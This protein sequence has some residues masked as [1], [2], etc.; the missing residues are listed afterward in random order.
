MKL[1]KSFMI[2]LTII[3]AFSM[4]LAACGQN[5]AGK[6]DNKSGNTDSKDGDKKAAEPK[7][8]GTLVAG[9]QSDSGFEGLLERGFYSG[10]PDD[11]IL[12]FMMD[13]LFKYDDEL[14]VQPHIAEWDTKD[15]QTYTFK[16]KEGVKWHNGEELTVEDWKYALEVIAH[17]DYEGPRYTNVE[18]IKGAEEYKKGKAK[19]ISGI[20]VINDYEIEITFIE[21]RVNH[22][23][24]IWSYPMPRKH[25]EGIAV[26][27][28]SKSPKVRKEPIGLGPF[29]VKKVQGNEY[30]EMER[31]DDYWQGKPKLDKLI[32]K[33][34]D[35]SLVAGALK[36]GEIDYMDVAPFQLEELSKLDNIEVHDVPDVSY[37][38]VGFKFG[39]WDKKEGKAVMDNKKFQNKDLRK[40]MLY[41]ID[42]EALI[43]AYLFDK[44]KVLNTVIPSNHWIAA[45]PSELEDYK[46]DPEK[47]KELL[48]KAGYKDVNG[49]GFVED[50]DGK[51]FK[52]SFSA[53]AKDSTYEGRAQQLLQNWKDVGLNV[54]L[55]S[56]KLLDFDLMGEMKDKD[57]PSIELYLAG[58]QT[59][60]DPD[61]TGLWA[62][63]AFWN[64]PRWVNE[65]SD[66]LLKEALG[67]KAME[68][69]NYRKDTYV[70]WQKLMNEELPVLPLWEPVDLL[71]M[72]KRVHGPHIGLGTDTKLHE[73][74]VSE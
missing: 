14:K 12:N 24:N 63:N 44:A 55:N 37:W 50:P 17:K 46:Y 9:L 11:Y 29:K 67:K 66:T 34:V 25:Y 43:K 59:G 16:F 30:V 64:H 22:I 21:P 48:A 4:V 41:A 10:S 45:D 20:K 71:A 51:E 54:E 47:A 2:L 18:T 3:L 74:F 7:E 69:E 5:D 15:N 70:K 52:I 36:N 42:R 19:E 28:L 72:N 57:D 32:V 6:A 73:W 31:F 8:G 1:K 26:K 53:H 61:P 60:A 49:D 65:E 58:W 35:P 38:F 13:N 62:S 68:D 33:V 39:H 23:E 56:G 40:A 27:D